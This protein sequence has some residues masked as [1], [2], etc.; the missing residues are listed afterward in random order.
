MSIVSYGAS[1]ANDSELRLCG[2]VNGKRVLELGVGTPSNAIDFALQGARSMA[3]D[4][5]TDRITQLR[6]QAE[7][8][9]VTVQCHVGDVAD[10]GF[11]TSASVDLAIAVN[12]L[13]AVDDLARLLR[14]G[15]RGA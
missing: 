2:D 6:R 12:T 13:G 11:A 1:V 10:L 4:P 14:A 7:Q 5:S 15:R 8:A 3:I 9:E